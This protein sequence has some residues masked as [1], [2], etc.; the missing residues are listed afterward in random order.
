MNLG[1]TRKLYTAAFLAVWLLGLAAAVGECA[2]P[3]TRTSG[4]G[5]SLKFSGG[6]GYFLDGG[7][8]LENLRLA[9]TAFYQE[10]KSVPAYTKT[11]ANWKKMS[12]APNFDAE[13]IYHFSEN[14]GIGIGTGYLTVRSKGDYGHNY[15]T[16][17][18]A[19]F[20]TFTM[21]DDISYQ[22]EYKITAIPV[23]LNFHFYFPA[24]DL[25]FYAYAGA[26]YYFA[27]LTHTFISDATNTVST[28][29]S[30]FDNT[31]DEITERDVVTENAKPSRNKALGFQGG[32]GLE[33][34]LM[35]HLAL[36]LEF[37][38]RY[39]NFSSWSGDFK[40]TFT[41]RRREW[42]EAEGWVS[43]E[44]TQDNFSETGPLWYYESYSEDLGKYFGQMF[45]WQNKPEDLFSQNARHAKI[46]LNAV[47]VALSLRFF[48]NF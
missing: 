23:K 16:E 24:G 39:A 8:D 17:G 3:Q 20:G 34:K 18:S 28:F 19:W 31:K 21:E 6:M 37:Y 36:G 11:W 40:E 35:S 25:N 12:Q 41:Q 4:K 47:G 26:S 29:S 9:R 13:L 14:F 1:N 10:L 38:G 43:D 42:N 15:Q 44:T 27:K 32:L 45:I 48:F 22:R 5:F 2:Q 7:G 30:I 46:N 33:L